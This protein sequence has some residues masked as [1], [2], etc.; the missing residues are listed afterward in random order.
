M[1]TNMLKVMKT[2]RH[3]RL[4]LLCVAILILTFSTFACVNIVGTKYNGD[5]MTSGLSGVVRLRVALARDTRPDGVKMETQLRGSTNFT[6]RSDYSAALM[7]LGRSEEAVQLLTH[8]EQEKPG[9]YFI[10]GNLGTAYELCG[11]NRAALHW[12]QQE[13]QRNPDAHN[14]TEWLH[15]K[16]LKAKIAAEEDPAYFTKHSVLNLQPSEIFIAKIVNM[17]GQTMS[18]RDLAD[19][20]EDQLGERLQFVKPPDAPVASLL[21]DYAAIEA[22]TRS[23]ESAKGVL[24]MALK[25]GYPPD[26]V[27]PLMKLYDQRIAMRRM[28]DGAFYFAIGVA[29]LGLLF[30]LYK[31]G[32]FVL[33]SKDLKR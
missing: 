6:D 15:A 23:L 9:E 28:R 5:R 33:S 19:A 32:I 16:I 22:G 29:F 31:K 10:A 1:A 26:Q 14:G 13:I 27:E 2:R 24:N 4:C 18:P 8:L 30:A 7:Y 21:F 3:M 20:I 25:Y 12:I 11:S 17:D